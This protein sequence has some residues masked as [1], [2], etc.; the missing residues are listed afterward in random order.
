MLLQCLGEELRGERFVYDLKFSDRIAEAAGQLGAEPLV[1]RSGHAFLRT[2][3]C[4]T[5]AVFGAEVSGHYFYKALDGGDDGLY[6]ACLVIAHLARLG[7]DVGRA[8]P[9]LP[10]GLHDARSAASDAAERSADASSSRFARPGPRF[11][12][13]TIDGVRIDMPGG[14]ALVRSSVTEPALTFRFE[15][16]D[17]H[18]LDDLVERFCDTMPEFGDE[19]WGHF[20]A[21]VGGVEQ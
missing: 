2:R 4:D 20:K 16:L 9:R 1:E 7:Q 10:G 13:K 21:A 18:A 12:S 19:L 11:R 6:T 17:W 8:A 14:W 3:M 15:G 5:T